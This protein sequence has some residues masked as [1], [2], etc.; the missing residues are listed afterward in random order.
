MLRV[1][2]VIPVLRAIRDRLR[3]RTLSLDLAA[4]ILDVAPTLYCEPGGLREQDSI[5]EEAEQATSHQ[6]RREHPPGV[7]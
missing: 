4:A 5:A 3:H 1:D 6:H 2:A 7:A